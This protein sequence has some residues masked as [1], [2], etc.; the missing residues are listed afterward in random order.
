MDH[1][2]V[3]GVRSGAI[4]LLAAA[5]ICGICRES[6]AEPGKGSSNPPHQ[7]AARSQKPITPQASS[8]QAAL[9]SMRYYGGPKSPMWRAAN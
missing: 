5:F 8:E 7:T 1:V 6:A 2:A 9:G 3:R 4:A